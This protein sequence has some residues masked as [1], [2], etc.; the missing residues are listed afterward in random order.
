MSASA[1]SVGVLDAGVLLAR[2]KDDHPLHSRAR[3]LLDRCSKGK[4]ELHMSIVNLAETLEHAAPLMRA[5]GIDPVM[6]LHACGVQVHAPDIN[7]ARRVAAL[8]TL[9]DA[10]LADRFAAATTQALQ[11]R[12]YTTDRALARVLEERR[13]PVTRLGR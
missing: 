4:V 11:A 6:V 1:G 12:L 3:D 13:I 7:I 2:L 10:S 9:Q 8:A 5:T